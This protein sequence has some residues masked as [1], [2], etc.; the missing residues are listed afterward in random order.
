M[1]RSVAG[2]QTLHQPPLR[3]GPPRGPGNE[4][5]GIDQS[6]VLVNPLPEP[7]QKQA[8]PSSGDGCGEIGQIGFDRGH[9][10]RGVDV[11]EGVGGE[12]ADQSGAPVDVLENPFGCGGRADPEVLFESIVPG[13]RKIG[14]GELPTDEGPLEIE[15]EHDVKVVGHLVSLDTDQRRTDD[16]QRPLDFL[17]GCARQRCR[18]HPP[19]LRQAPLPER[20]RATDEILP[21]P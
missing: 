20:E 19:R 13:D 10:L 14:H 9:H 6:P 11:A 18:E 12:V 7:F 5:P 15:A 1:G 21:Q 17:G 3:D 2:P 4:R 16:E 8:E